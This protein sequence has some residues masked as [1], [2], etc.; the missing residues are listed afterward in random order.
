MRSPG[1]A[2]P[3]VQAARPPA[4]LRSSL[5]I[6]PAS[7]HRFDASLGS[8]GVRASS[9]VNVQECVK[10]VRVC[11][12]E[13]TGASSAVLRGKKGQKQPQDGRGFGWVPTSC[14]PSV[15]LHSCSTCPL[16]AGAE[17]LLGRV[18]T[19]PQPCASC[20]RVLYC[21]SSICASERATRFP[22]HGKRA[23]VTNSPSS[24]SSGLD[25]H[26]PLG[27]TTERPLKPA[28]SL[29]KKWEP[30]AH[31]MR[32]TRRGACSSKAARPAPSRC[33]VTAAAGAGR[34]ATA[35]TDA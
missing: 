11:G 8:H 29:V 19:T 22:K 18:H 3:C 5:H 23:E 34:R 4:A 21:Q 25:A 2:R 28:L 13:D 1:F 16:R 27:S 26:L 10:S 30:P 24:T 31:Q 9:A 17:R 7:A 20:D 33:A 14:T 15:G 12:G 32:S 6:R 35:H